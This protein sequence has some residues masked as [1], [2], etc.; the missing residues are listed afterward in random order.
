MI[1]F[2]RDKNDRPVAGFMTRVDVTPR[3]MA[4][5]LLPKFNQF[6]ATKSAVETAI[7]K[8]LRAHGGMY[9]KQH[10]ADVQDW[11]RRVERMF[12]LYEYGEDDGDPRTPEFGVGF[13]GG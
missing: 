2:R 9:A 5:I 11:T 3:E 7:R 13:E 12:R 4:C 10:E 8:H 6:P 1:R